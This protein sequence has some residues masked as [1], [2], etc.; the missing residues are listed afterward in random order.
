M[1]DMLKLISVRADLKIDDLNLSPF[2]IMHFNLLVNPRKRYV[3]D[4][5]FDL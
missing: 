2:R 1:S 4:G 3:I 5:V